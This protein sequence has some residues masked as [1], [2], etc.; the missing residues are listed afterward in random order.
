MKLERSLKFTL[1][2]I[3][4]AIAVLFALAI[5]LPWIVHWFVEVKH[6]D[7]NLPAVAMITCYPCLPFAVAAL[8]YLRKFL[9]N[10]LNGLVFGDKNVNALRVVAICCLCGSVITLIATFSYFPFFVL[11][12]ASAACALIVN[13]IQDIFA[14]ELE[15]RREK[16]LDDVRDEL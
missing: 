8:L 2:V 1:Y 13:C 6:K 12:I 10:C 15:A 16:I 14:A 9:K 11:S 5:A 4:F 3:T 7:P